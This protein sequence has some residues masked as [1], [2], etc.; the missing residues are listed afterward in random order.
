M[1]STSGKVIPAATSQLQLLLRVHLYGLHLG[2]IVDPF[3]SE[4][5]EQN[6]KWFAN[7]MKLKTPHSFFIDNG[8]IK[9]TGAGYNGTGELRYHMFI[10][11]D[12]RNLK[13]FTK[14]AYGCRFCRKGQRLHDPTSQRS[15]SPSMFRHR[16]EE[17]DEIAYGCED[18]QQNMGGWGMADVEEPQLGRNSLLDSI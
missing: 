4:R 14:Y 1:P 10:I 18:E 15:R 7:W 13:Y 2:P 16:D 3:Q 5:K 17:P 9:Q 8:Y 11:P 12:D 6:C